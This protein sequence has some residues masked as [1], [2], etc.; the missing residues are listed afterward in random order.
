LYNAAKDCGM[1]LLV[2]GHYATETVGVKALMPLVSDVF[3]VDTVFVEDP[4]DL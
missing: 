1:N 4:K 3:G 2:A